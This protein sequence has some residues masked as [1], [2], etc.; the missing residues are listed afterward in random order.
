VGTWQVGAPVGLPS[1]VKVVSMTYGAADLSRA[2]MRVMAS[3]TE[4][5]T[6]LLSR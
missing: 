1:D 4:M 6:F 5:L 3:D 2:P